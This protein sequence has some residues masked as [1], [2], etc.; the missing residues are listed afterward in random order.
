MAAK[1]SGEFAL[2]ERYLAPL[3]KDFAP[4]LRLKDDAAVFAPPPG[5]DIV[6]TA[7]AMVEGIHF[8]P[9]DPPDNVARKLLRVNLSDLAAMGAAP[10]AYF[11]TLALPPSRGDHW[12]AG[13]SAGLAVD[14]QTFGLSLAGG[15]TVATRGP[16]VL[17]LTAVGLVPAGRALRR[18][19]ARA[20]DGIY[21]SGSIGD[22]ALAL[23]IR[24]NRVPDPGPESR[25]WLAH[26]LALPDPRL[27]LGQGLGGLATAAIDVSDGLLADTGHICE[28]SGVGAVLRAR[29]VPLSAAAALIVGNDPDRLALALSGGDDYELVFTAP[30]AR[31]PEVL[32]LGSRAVGVTRIGEIVPGH[33]VALLDQAGNR[34]ESPRRG[35]AHF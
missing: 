25:A 17:S 23:E 21:V 26:R 35:Y 22:A 27:A 31:A 24:E 30:P 28:N 10:Y 2:I 7:D 29:D 1:T 3:A 32:A 4:A 15:D 5:Q 18:D 16:A 13:L 11:L 14:Q 19:G 33:G 20:G 34:M 12:M 9:D 6:I 8:F